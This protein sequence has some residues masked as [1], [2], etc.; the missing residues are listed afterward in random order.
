MTQ[1]E[2]DQNPGAAVA[3]DATPQ[4]GEAQEGAAATVEEQLASAEQRASEYEDR[5]L[6]TRADMENYK[7]R[8]ERTYADLAKSGKKDLLGRLL[9]VKD[10]LERALR[11]GESAP[12]GQDGG[13]LEGVRLTQ[14]QLDQLLEQ[15][16]VKKIEAQGQIFD[17]A[18]EE[19]VQTVTDPSLPDHAVV[20]VAREGYMYGDEVLRP[21]QVIVNV[22]EN[23]Q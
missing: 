2:Q 10:N 20:Q 22:L 23:G 4:T 6:R 13:I 12:E 17:P 8:I 11:Y 9:G 15:Q 16:G 7:K 21:A 3:S 1:Q 18:L 14:Y 19:A 5:Y